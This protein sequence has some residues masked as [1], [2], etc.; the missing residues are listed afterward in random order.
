MTTPPSPLPGKPSHR[1]SE[2]ALPT[3]DRRVNLTDHSALYTP[4]SPR[5]TNPGDYAGRLD[6]T[7]HVVSTA[8]HP[9]ERSDI[10]Q[11]LSN[12]IEIV[13]NPLDCTVV[14][15]ERAVFNC[16]GTNRRLAENRTEP[17]LV[18]E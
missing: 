13:F 11:N 6:L 3:V 7:T 1:G 9:Q 15:G 12:P 4:T 18:L 8:A 17:A 10:S 14:V 16:K 2:R 5:A